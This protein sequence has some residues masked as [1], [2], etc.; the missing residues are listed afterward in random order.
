MVG[1]TIIVKRK[2]SIFSLFAGEGSLEAGII[3]GDEIFL[4]NTKAN[5]VRGK[6]VTIGSGCEIERVEFQDEFRVD[7][8][9][10]VKEHKK[11][12]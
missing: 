12:G 2:S 5:V 7:E 8:K 4:E 1:E 6:R 3:E 11:M 9:S 10:I